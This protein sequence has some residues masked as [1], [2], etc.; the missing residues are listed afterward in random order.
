MGQ[1][2][3]PGY[4]G[5]S[6]GKCPGCRQRKANEWSMRIG[7]EMLS[8]DAYFNTLTIDD[9]IINK[10]NK[11]KNETFEAYNLN[12]RMLQL[13]HKRIGKNNNI[14]YFSVG[15]YGGMFGRAHY[16]EI[17][18]DY[19]KTITPYEIENNYQYGQS[20]RYYRLS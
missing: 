5:Y 12:K 1:C 18:L 19:N 8:A 11:E 4:K 15:E 14:K 7:W 20:N 9:E 10:I 3:R 13:Y 17:L 6:C 16:H 2:T